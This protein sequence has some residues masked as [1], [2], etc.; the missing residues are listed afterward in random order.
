MR[1]CAHIAC[2][3]I[4]TWGAHCQGAP[5]SS[6]FGCFALN[7]VVGIAPFFSL[8]ESAP[9]S[10][11]CRIISALGLTQKVVMKA[12]AGRPVGSNRL[13]KNGKAPA[14]RPQ[15]LPDYW[16]APLVLYHYKLICYYRWAASLGLRKQRLAEVLVLSKAHGGL[17]S[18][19]LFAPV[20]TP[21][22]G[23]ASLRRRWYGTAVH[24]PA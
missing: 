3:S 20:C 8:V 21:W 1:K 12:P 17:G 13:D 23:W 10:L 11:R 5:A 4:E 19:W 22:Q 18:M 7:A 24:S 14:G 16:A 2:S 15:R 9:N 6:C